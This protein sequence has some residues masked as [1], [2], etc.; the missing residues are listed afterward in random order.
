MTVHEKLDTLLTNIGNV[1]GFSC[2]INGGGTTHTILHDSNNARVFSPCAAAI[3]TI[4]HN[5]V[6]I[7]MSNRGAITADNAGLSASDTFVVKKGDT[8]EFTLV[9]YVG[10]H[11]VL[12]Y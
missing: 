2:V 6:A 1:G 4:K 5:G 9:S 7:V 10:M 3:T 11:A 12:I 8:I